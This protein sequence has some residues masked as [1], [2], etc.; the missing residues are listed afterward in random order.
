MKSVLVVFGDKLPRRNK[1]WWQ[2]IDEVIAPRIIR[3]AIPSGKIA[4]VDIE[5]LSTP[6]S[7][8]EANALAVKLPDLTLADG[9]KIS[10]SANWQGYDL[11]WLHYE[12]LLWKFCLPYTQYKELL[13]RLKDFDRVYLYRA[14]YPSFFQYFLRAHG[15]QC[16]ILK[17]FALRGVLP[18]PPGVALQL[19]LSTLFLPVLRIKGPQLMLYTSDKVSPP[20]NFEFRSASMYGELIE[21]R[22]SLAI[23][24]RSLEPWSRV[25]KNAWKRK[26]AVIYSSAIVEAMRLLSRPFSHS[27]VSFSASDADK[28]FWLSVA[29]HF[30]G[31]ARGDIWSIKILGFLL[32]WLRVR[33]A[34]V[35]AACNRTFHEVLGCK[36]AGIKTVGIQHAAI[37]KH[38]FVADFLPGYAGE[39]SISLDKYGVW[40]EWWKEYY[41][42]YSSVYGQEQLFVS[43][44][45]NPFQVKAAEFPQTHQRMGNSP[46]KVLFISEQLA[47]PSEVMPYLLRLLKEKDFEVTMKFRP[48]R[49]GFENWLKENQPEILE[50]IKISKVSP[51]EAAVTS[52]VVVGSHSTAVLEG[53]SQRKPIFFFWTDKWGDYFDL[54]DWGAKDKFFASSPEELVEY[55][56][57]SGNISQELIN[58][59]Q[60]RFF[61]QPGKN[62][63]KWVVDQALEFAKN[64]ERR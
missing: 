9:R 16:D 20:Y 62:G 8:Q 52:D 43:G 58:R 32:R 24:M 53:L 40:S 6:G 29:T 45:C 64:Y 12:D 48:Y 35:P 19:L 42:K 49:D 26:R 2:Q 39:K 1:S 28:R 63:G 3:G 30:L 54:K 55:I 5:S 60:E 41:L 14:A 17:P 4:F 56:K 31:D 25:L 13:L 47:A 37:P 57:V 61:G 33:A 23:F 50:K 51:Q 11:W 10:R 59:L 34:I 44:P 46:L 36:L 7:M 38:A 21:R 15:R 18:I 27:S 22:L